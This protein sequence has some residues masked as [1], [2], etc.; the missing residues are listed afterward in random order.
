MAASYSIGP[1][2]PRSLK[3]LTTKANSPG[4]FANELDDIILRLCAV[5]TV[6]ISASGLLREQNADA[7]GDTALAIQRFGSDP[8]SE[9]ADRLRVLRRHIQ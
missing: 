4:S 2:R 3:C 6:L 9:L 7:D 1:A 5:R 8:L